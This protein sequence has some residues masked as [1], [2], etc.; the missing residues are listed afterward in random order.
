MGWGDTAAEPFP[1]D[2]EMPS[3]KLTAKEIEPYR[4]LL[5]QMLAVLSG[6]IR[7]LENEA[8]SGETRS[9]SPEDVGTELSSM[10][11]SLEL[12]ERDEKTMREVL[13]A[14]ERIEQG[15]FGLC[16]SCEK[17]IA[18]TR[19]K[20]MPHARHCIA[21]QRELEAEGG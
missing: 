11:L 1:S 5:R 9:A 18:R 7:T 4:K 2:D 19:L 8:L 20:Y 13:D 10:E 12:L 16:Q 17:P 6:D 21:C 15:T 14:L 3:K